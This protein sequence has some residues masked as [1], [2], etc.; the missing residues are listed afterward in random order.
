MD[1]SHWPGALFYF[2]LEDAALLRAV[3]GSTP[4]K[5]GVLWGLDYDISADRHVPGR[6]WEIAPNPEAR[7]LVDSAVAVVHSAF[8]RALRERKPGLIHMV[9]GSPAL[10]GRWTR[11][12]PSTGCS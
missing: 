3:I 8:A 10:F 4:G 7:R 12:S 5:R 6:L 11:P 9:G 1:R 2:W